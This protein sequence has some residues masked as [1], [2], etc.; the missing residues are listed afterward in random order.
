MRKLGEVP[1][2]TRSACARCRNKAFEARN[3]Q[4]LLL[5]APPASGKSR[6]LMFIALDK[7]FNQGLKKVVV[8][9]PRTKHRLLPSPARRS[10]IVA[11]FA[12]WVVE[13]RNNLCTP[14]ADAS[15]V[16][17]S[18]AISRGCLIRHYFAR[19]RR[20]GL[21]TTLWMKLVQR[22]HCSP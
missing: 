14:G 1:R 17:A 16:Q 20:C 15:K 22:R 4:Y 21:R 2:R 10:R 13:D 6:A 7:L 12:D 11:F 3:N 8:C 19:M 9:C 18:E 5:K